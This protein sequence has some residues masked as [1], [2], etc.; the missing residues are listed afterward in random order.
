MVVTVV[1]QRHGPF[2][3]LDTVAIAR[4]K[5]RKTRGGAVARRFQGIIKAAGRERGPR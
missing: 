3:L 4:L 5:R 1:V 2:H